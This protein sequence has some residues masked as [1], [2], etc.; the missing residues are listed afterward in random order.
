MSKN[1]RTVPAEVVL[2]LPSS[3]KDAAYRFAK[4][5]ET[6]Q[7]IAR[8]LI[9]ANPS[10]PEEVS[11]N[12]KA[13]LFA[14]FMLRAHELWG[15]DVYMLGE[16][17]TLIKIANTGDHDHAAKVE[18]K[19]GL[20]EYN[21]NVAFAMSPQEFGQMR[22][23]DPQA[24]SI[25]KYWRDK[26]AKYASNNLASLKL[27]ARLVKNDGKTR[28]RSDIKDF[29]TALVDMFETFDKKCKVAQD[30]RK[31]ATANQVQ[32]RVARDA[33]WKAYKV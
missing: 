16:G 5:G 22:N 24:H 14:G 27:Q 30:M 26:F 31:D 32:F 6:A 19:K 7:S 12:L 10:F 23:K 1:A 33:F 8:Y 13:D 15:S 18:G 17:S 29:T 28:E 4:T 9:D 25:L 21:V 11:D 3:A 2:G 20:S